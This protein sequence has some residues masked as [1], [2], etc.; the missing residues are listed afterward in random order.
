MKYLLVAVLLA[1]ACTASKEQ[2]DRMTAVQLTDA[3]TNH[4]R[5]RGGP[6][7]SSKFMD[8]LR[9]MYVKKY[10]WIWDDQTQADVRSGMFRIGMTKEMVQASIGYPNDINKTVGSWGVHEQWVYGTNT[11]LYFEDGVLTSYQN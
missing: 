9:A 8:D 2:I 5:Y 7:Y 10:G 4:R 1:V 6:Y 11:Y 3:L